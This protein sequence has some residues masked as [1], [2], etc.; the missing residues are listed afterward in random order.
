MR[1]GGV[2]VGSQGMTNWPGVVFTALNWIGSGVQTICLRCFLHLSVPLKQNRLPGPRNVRLV[3]RG[4]NQP[5]TKRCPILLME[6]RL[7]GCRTS[8]AQA[9]LPSAALHAL[10]ASFRQL[11]SRDGPQFA[12][13][14]CVE[15]G[16]LVGFLRIYSSICCRSSGCWPRDRNKSRGLSRLVASSSET[17][18]QN[19]VSETLSEFCMDSTPTSFCSVVPKRRL[20]CS[21]RVIGYWAFC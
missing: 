6:I 11:A 15:Y 8:A 9:S 21:T 10:P 20:F 12:S 5:P 18:R 1:T 7:K 17:W 2:F 13:S 19:R 14:C 16:G 3:D 4:V